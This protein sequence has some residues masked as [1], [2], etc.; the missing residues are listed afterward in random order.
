MLLNRDCNHWARFVVGILIYGV[1]V[2][3]WLGSVG[4]GLGCE[5]YFKSCFTI[6]AKRSYLMGLRELSIL[7]SEEGLK[8]IMLWNLAELQLEP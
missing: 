3:V 7:W 4:C 8:G 6:T 1:W 2:V 5:R